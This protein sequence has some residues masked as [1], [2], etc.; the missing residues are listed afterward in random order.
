MALFIGMFGQGLSDEVSVL[1][2]RY[3][4]RIGRCRLAFH[5]LRVHIMEYGLCEMRSRCVGCFRD[6]PKVLL[7]CHQVCR[8]MQ[9]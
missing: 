6:A 9:V 5:D 2:G 4:L 7:K 1:L 8:R 3:M